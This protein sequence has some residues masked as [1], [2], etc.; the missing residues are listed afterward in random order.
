MIAWL[1]VLSAMCYPTFP[2]RL[3]AST[4]APKHGKRVAS[5]NA[6]G[7]RVMP[8]CVAPNKDLATPVCVTDSKIYSRLHQ[9]K[10]RGVKIMD[11]KKSLLNDA[12]RMKVAK[13]QPSVRRLKEIYNNVHADRSIASAMYCSVCRATQSKFCWCGAKLIGSMCA[14]QWSQF[15]IFVRSPR[16]PVLNLCD[17]ADQAGIMSVLA[18]LGANST[19]ELLRILF[20][21]A[22]ISNEAVMAEIGEQV[23]H[24][25]FDSLDR[26]FKEK[27]VQQLPTFRAGQFA[28]AVSVSDLAK[29]LKDFCI[30]MAPKV[31]PLFDEWRNARKRK[32]CCVIAFRKLLQVIGSCTVYGFGPYKKTKFAEFLTLAAMAKMHGLYFEQRWLNALSDVWPIPD[33]S[34]AN[35]AR[36][37][38][39]V[40]NHREGIIA[41]LRG[42]RKQQHFTF[43]TIVAQL[44]FWSEQRNGRLSWL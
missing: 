43:P 14:S 13:K 2:K 27:S 42:L 26:M 9:R 16:N 24:S 3:G 17:P 20:V 29:V 19:L 6:W 21:V 25:R 28:G 22:M 37:F 34:K 4:C 18:K 31:R 30:Y 15:M 32:V 41:L 1:G 23:K 44:C 36:I 35:L 39:G 40:L 33:N 5:N 38:P 12:C 11:T 10:T 7:S 8:A